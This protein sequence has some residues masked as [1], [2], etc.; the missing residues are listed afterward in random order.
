M[1]TMVAR[2]ANT[3]WVSSMFGGFK[4]GM[5]LFNAAQECAAATRERRTPSASALHTLGLDEAAFR[6]AVKRA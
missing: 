5:S 3:N 1:T 6:R 2:Y 4:N